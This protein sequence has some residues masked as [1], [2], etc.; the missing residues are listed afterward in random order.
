MRDVCRRLTCGDGYEGDEEDSEHQEGV[1]CG[2]HR[3][4]SCSAFIVTAAHHALVRVRQSACAGS[5]VAFSVRLTSQ[6]L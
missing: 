2:V 1:V 3:A 4:L 5:C 6:T